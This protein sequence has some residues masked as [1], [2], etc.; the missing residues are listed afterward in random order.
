M[1]FIYII[2]YI[3]YIDVTI[4][5]FL[6]SVPLKSLQPQYKESFYYY[7]LISSKKIIK[8]STDIVVNC[9]PLFSYNERENLNYLRRV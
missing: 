7:R 2:L 5:S 4:S 9:F 3:I 1:N 8:I 6:R